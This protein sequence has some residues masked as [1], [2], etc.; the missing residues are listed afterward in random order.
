MNILCNYIAV[1]V[2]THTTKSAISSLLLINTGNCQKMVKF[3]LVLGT[4]EIQWYS[5]GYLQII[6]ALCL[7]KE[8]QKPWFYIVT[9]GP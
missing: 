3:R 9:T 5:V 8:A 1:W 4:T 7:A 2:A 6:K